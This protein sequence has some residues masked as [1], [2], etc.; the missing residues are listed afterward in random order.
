MT[1]GKPGDGDADPRA[2]R[3]IAAGLRRRVETGELRPGQ[4][5]P[6]ITA[7]AGQ[8]GHARQTCGKALRLLEGEGLLARYPGLGYYVAG[9]GPG[10]GKNGGSLLLLLLL[11][12]LLNDPV[13]EAHGSSCC[14]RC[15]PALLPCPAYWPPPREARVTLAEA[16]RRLGPTSSASTS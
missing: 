1:S 4:A 16:F 11:L 7:L 2:Y 3:R 9:P 15:A 8:T 10:S 13:P 5:V 12:L 14:C 6:S